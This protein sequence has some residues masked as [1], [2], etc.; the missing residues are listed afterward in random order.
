MPPPTLPDRIT[1]KW[2]FENLPWD[3]WM[4]LAGMVV[5]GFVLGTGVGQI[6]IVREF[7]GRPTPKIVDAPKA[8][9]QQLDTRLQQLTEAHNQ[10]LAGID[11]GIIDAEAKAAANIDGIYYKD[12]ADRLRQDRIAE[13]ETFARELALLR[14]T[15]DPQETVPAKRAR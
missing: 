2:L 7:L 12:S 13:N 9:P 6:E 3:L 11:K 8:I 4:W 5:A 15:I 10:R 14:A 1:I